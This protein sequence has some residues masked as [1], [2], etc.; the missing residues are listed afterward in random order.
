MKRLLI[1]FMLG[2]VF[3]A[4]YAIED[5]PLKQGMPNTV[6]LSNGEVINDLTGEWAVSIAHYGAWVKHGIFPDLLEIKQDICQ[7][8]TILAF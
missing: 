5:N 2:L 6:T 4:A 3:T 7:A 1:I 8:L